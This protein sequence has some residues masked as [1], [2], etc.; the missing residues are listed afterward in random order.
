[1]SFK[2]IILYLKFSQHDSVPAAPFKK[3]CC[4]WT[5]QQIGPLTIHTHRYVSIVIPKIPK[6]Q[7][8]FDKH[9]STRKKRTIMKFD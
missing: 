1:M 4:R 7:L 3:L 2:V 9:E 6:I 5:M 8:K